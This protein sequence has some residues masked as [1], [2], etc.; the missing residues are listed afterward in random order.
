MQKSLVVLMVSVVTAL[1]LPEKSFRPVTV[2]G[3]YEE[4]LCAVEPPSEVVSVDE[5]RVSLLQQHGL[6]IISDVS[7]PMEVLCAQICTAEPNCTDFNSRS[8]V[9]RCEMFFCRPTN[10]TVQ[11]NC[12]Q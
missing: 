9:K 5:L 11:P 12:M 6:A 8:D 7:I 4:A 3:S 10:C 2:P 1:M